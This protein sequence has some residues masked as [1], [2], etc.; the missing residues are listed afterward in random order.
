MLSPA[1]LLSGLR[2]LFVFIAVL[3][4]V[5]CA[6][7]LGIGALAHAN[8]ERALA[9]GFYVVGVAVLIGSFILGIRGPLRADWGEGEEDW[10]TRPARFMPRLIRRTTADERVEAKRSSLGLFAL[11]LAFILIG[12]GFDPSRNAF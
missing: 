5:T 11:G 9:D 7:S 6:V 2:R 12:A 8:L 10:S 4:G 1:A 3:F